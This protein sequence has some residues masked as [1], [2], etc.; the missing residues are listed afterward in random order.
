MKQELHL[1]TAVVTTSSQALVFPFASP[2]SH[3]KKW[4]V[5]Y[6]CWDIAAAAATGNHQAV[7]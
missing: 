5:S 1:M 3:S 6:H 2:Y 4:K 7:W